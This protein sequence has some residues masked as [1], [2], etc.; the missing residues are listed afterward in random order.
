MTDNQK[1]RF[2]PESQA[3]VEGLTHLGYL[4]KSFQ[5]C[6]HRFTLRTL[7]GNEDLLVGLL[8]K[9]YVETMA[10]AKAWTIAHVALSL[11]AIDG[12]TDFCPDASFDELENARGRFQYVASKWQYPLIDYIFKEFA[13]LAA[14]QAEAFEAAKDFSNRSLSKPTPSPSSLNE[15]GGS[16]SGIVSDSPS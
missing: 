1:P 9:E 10:Q 2:K 8:T 13:V 6:G 3:A 7:Y 16:N 11:V 12:S 14:E 15:P 4:T 5:Y